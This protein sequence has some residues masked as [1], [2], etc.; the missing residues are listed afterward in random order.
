RINREV[1]T[2][3]GLSHKNIAQLYG[4]TR[5]T[6]GSVGLI[7]PFF[8]NGNIV[9]YMKSPDT[10]NL[11]VLK[12]MMDIVEGVSY[13]HGVNVVHGDIK[14]SNIMVDDDGNVKLIDFGVSRITGESGNT[15]SGPGLSWAWAA[16]ELLL[17][18]DDEVEPVE[19]S[20][21]SDVYALAITFFEES[22]RAPFLIP[23]PEA[24]F[25]RNRS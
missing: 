19:K 8:K 3:T 24:R 11:D 14:G 17:P 6:N 5:E 23:F 25:V 12:I 21:A 4:I 18:P 15:T 13:L 20:S 2:W 16:P 10:P 1:H 22:P 9:A 7:S